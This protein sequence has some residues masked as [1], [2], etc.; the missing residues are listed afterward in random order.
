MSLKRK[1]KEASDFAYERISQIRGVEPIKAS[2]AM[3]MM[4]KINIDEFADIEDDIDFC[5]MFLN[6]ECTLTFPA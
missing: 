4:V 2:A 3:Y 1:L 6:E 5:K